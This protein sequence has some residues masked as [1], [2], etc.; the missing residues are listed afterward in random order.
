MC[1]PGMG[2]VS[3]SVS[4]LLMSGLTPWGHLALRPAWDQESLCV[5]HFDYAPFKLVRNEFLSLLFTG[6]NGSPQS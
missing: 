4:T 5:E 1:P 2:K 3:R 6:Q